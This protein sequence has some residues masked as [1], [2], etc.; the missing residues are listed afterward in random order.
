MLS[1]IIVTDEERDVA[2][3]DIPNAFIQMRVE[4]EKYM[5]FINICGVNIPRCVQVARHNR[6]KGCETVAGTVPERAVSHD[7]CKPSILP[8]F[9]NSLT[10]VGFKINPCDLCV[11]NNMID[12]Q[13]MTICYN[14]YDCKLSHS[15]SKDN[16]RMIKC[17]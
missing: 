15:S 1:C 14:V 8:K 6:Q 13:Q 17:M 11:A 7:G 3:I 12:G 16:D 9:T 4:D 10:D 2:V 5:A